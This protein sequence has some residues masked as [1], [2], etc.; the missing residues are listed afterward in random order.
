[1]LALGYACGSECYLT[2]DECFAAA[3]RLVVEKNARSAVHVV[4]LAV[5]FDNPES[6]E[7]GYGVW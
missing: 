1:M 3:L 6:V 2:C 4:C 5:F 7:L